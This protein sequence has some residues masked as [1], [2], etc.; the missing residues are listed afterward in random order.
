MRKNT[1]LL[2]SAA[3]LAGMVAGNGSDLGKVYAAGNTPGVT[4]F[5]TKE[6]LKTEFKLDGMSDGVED[7]VGRLRFGKNAYDEP[8]IWYIAGTDSGVTGENIVLFAAE[9]IL[10]KSQTDGTTIE[11]QKISANKFE[12]PYDYE[13][14]VDCQYSGNTPVQ[15]YSNHYGRSELRAKLRAMAES[16]AYFTKAEQGLMNATTVK[17]LDTKNDVIYTTT[18]KLYALSIWDVNACP[19]IYWEKG[20]TINEFTEPDKIYA[21]SGND[22]VIASELY[23]GTT[24]SGTYWLRSPATNIYWE[25]GGY[26]AQQRQTYY[27]I[28]VVSSTSKQLATESCGSSRAVKPAANLNLTN[29][30]FASAAEAAS[31]EPTARMIA[32]ETPM[33]LRLDGAVYGKAIG[34]VEYVENEG[35]IV[36]Q[37]DANATGTVS[38]VVQG[39]DGKDWYYSVVVDGSAVVTKEQLQKALGLSSVNF[40]DCR[41]WLETTEDNVSY[42]TALATERTQTTP[43]TKTTV[44]KVEL[45]GVI[46]VGGTTL[47]DYATCN[48]AGIA[49]ESLAIS[50][51]V[52]NTVPATGIAG[53]DTVY[54]ASFTLHTGL[55]GNQAYVF[56]DYVDVTVDGMTR[57]G[58]EPDQYGRLQVGQA[59]QTD[60]RKITDVATPA[61]PNGGVF[62]NYYTAADVLTNGA[63]SELGTQADVTLEGTTEVPPVQQPMDVEWTLDGGADYDATPGAKNTF[64]WTVKQAAYQ[65]YDTD[66]HEMTGTYEI[67]NK[68]ATPVSITGTDGSI[69]FDGT[70]I[71]VY[72][73]FKIDPNAGTATYSLEAGGT[74]KGTLNGTTLK[75][76]QAGTFFIKVSTAANSIYAA[77]TAT[78]TLTVDEGSIVSTATDYNGIY[79]GQPHSITVSVTEPSDVNV[80]YSTDGTN[81]GTENPKFTEAGSY[82]V[83]YKIEKENYASVTGKKTVTIEKRDIEIQAEDQT[84]L[85]GTAVDQ[86]RYIVSGN[87]LAVGDHIADIT[88][89]PST[90]ERTEN[91]AL[92]VGGVKIMNAAD[93]DV[94]ESYNISTVP[95]VLKITHNTTL[96]PDRIEAVKLRTVY[97]EGDVLNLDDLT[98]T[99]FYADGYSEVVTGYTTN[100][101]D[102]DMSVPEEKILTVSFTQNGETR[103]KDIVLTVDA[104]P[105]IVDAVELTGVK[106]VG[107]M[108]LAEN[109]G[110][111][112]AG[113]AA[114]TLT[115][116]YATVSGG[117]NVT[118]TG[119]AEWNTEYSA[120]VALRTAPDGGRAYVFADHVTVTVDGVAINVAPDANGSL[121]VTQKFTTDKRKITGIAAPT[122]PN[123]A[124]FSNYYTAADLLIDGGNGEL[125]TQTAVTL[126]GTTAVAEKTQ[127]MDVEWM[128]ANAGGVDY[129]ATP[130]AV[131][132]FRWTVKPD[133]Y[134]DYDTDNHEMTGICEIANRAATLVSIAG[135]DGSVAFN[136]TDID[137][138]QYFTIDPNAGAATYSLEGGTGVGTLNGTT[139]TVTQAG[140]FLIR[141]CTAASGNYAPGEETITL[142]VGVGGIVSTAGDY[143]GI[144][145]GRPH[146]IT[147]SVTEPSDAKVTYSTDGTNFGTENPE[148]TEAGSYAVTYKIEKENYTAVTGTKTVTIGKRDIEIKAE[149]QTVFWGMAV[150][151][152]KYAVSTVS[153]NDLAAGDHIAGITLTP[154]TSE[155]TENGT[156]AVGGVKIVNAAGEDVTGSYK[157]STV[158]GVLKITHNTTLAPDRIEAVKQRTVYKAGD[159]LNL[160]D[161]TVTAYYADGYSEGVTGYTTNAADINMSI[162]EAKIL[163]VSFT[164]NGV[165]RTKDIVL[166]VDAL[167]PVQYTITATAG[168]NGK[169][170]PEGTITVTQGGSQTFTIIPDS[171]YVIDT[172][173]IDGSAVAVS[174]SYTFSGITSNHSISVT[175]KPEPPVITLQPSDTSVKAGTPAVFRVTATGTKLAYQWQ[176]DHNDK[177][178]WVNISRAEAT[179]LTLKAV[180]QSQNG[181]RYRCII[182]NSSGSVTSNEVKLTV[183]PVNVEYKVIEGADSTFTLG[184]DESL[185]IRVDAELGK[186]LG[187]EMDGWTVDPANYTSWSGSTYVK[188]TKDYLNTLAVGTHTVKILFSDGYATTTVTIARNEQQNGGAVTPTPAPT[189]SEKITV[190]AGNTDKAA[191]KTGDNSIPIMVCVAVMVVCGAALVIFG[192]TRRREDK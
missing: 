9:P 174:T 185:T 97:K 144:Y 93:E 46:P 31:Q 50:Y 41:I 161:L 58:L 54:S 164:R 187:G 160:D 23:S 134:Q 136:G 153:G 83:E 85:W 117:D 94:T 15:V 101:A 182:S 67:A 122:V 84:I 74:G 127:P 116:S 121:H 184:E 98:V 172:L 111:N 51:T 42:A 157:V 145:D 168:A 25:N 20:Q 27:L 102:I 123:N 76:T 105:L 73:Y 108:T 75:V 148:F 155:R 36:A 109:A 125:G 142:T 44:S 62:S 47:A 86:T 70:D 68:A 34:T 99:A 170:T 119:I 92:T 16:E 12:D 77:G 126:E 162:P 10:G 24:S 66:N 55:V 30:L 189:P 72:G 128:L 26:G 45:T 149:N 8:Q 81:F 56:A 35:L 139:L 21:G 192:V 13:P 175:F 65:D 158:R 180:E 154:S 28:A 14:V 113:I 177:K 64:R 186:F 1:V 159:A 90:T 178:G 80:T 11:G 188:F 69:Y 104:V 150:D 156:L 61:I 43:I 63:N 124:V 5:A 6:E 165:T 173:T 53:W 138:F 87:A 91:A 103:T 183:V 7:T 115:L 120:S 106:P 49:A 118:V 17:T 40:A 18:D 179:E 2:L 38:L 48:T 143:S 22:I 32:G 176:V 181:F 107:G 133:A 112:T 110:C 146:S 89:T 57:R 163:K 135:R 151:Q 114:D 88:L 59:F 71:D 169:V 37:K 39:N 19:A 4:S 167:P 152:T 190:P 52:E 79:D 171:G 147:V 95:G 60:Q 141:V 100:A 78:I 29:V 82:E 166:T 140:T 132:T 3:L 191:P 33:V 96:A 137:V 129:D 130:G 131:N